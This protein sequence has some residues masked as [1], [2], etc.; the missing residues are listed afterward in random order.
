MIHRILLIV[1]TIAVDSRLLNLRSILV[2]LVQKAYLCKVA[3]STFKRI[4]G[5]LADHT[6]WQFRRLIIRRYVGSMTR[7]S[8]IFELWLQWP[9]RKCLRVRINIKIWKVCDRA[10][11]MTIYFIHVIFIIGLFWSDATSNINTNLSLIAHSKI[12]FIAPLQRVHYKWLLVFI[13]VVLLYRHLIK[14]LNRVKM[15]KEVSILW[16][17]GLQIRLKFIHLENSWCLM[18]SIYVKTLVS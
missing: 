6:R 9:I 2:M 11:L 7:I 14:F 4:S 1:V 8:T 10:I 17:S 13:N 12:V 15:S 16:N 3:E 18:W 5:V